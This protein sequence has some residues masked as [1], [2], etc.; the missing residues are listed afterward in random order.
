MDV[1]DLLEQDEVW[2][3]VHGTEHDISDM[4]PRY[5]GNVIRFMERKA[6]ALINGYAWS[7]VKTTSMP[8]ADTHAFDVVTAAFGAELDEMYRDPVAWLRELPLMKALNE[9][10][11]ASE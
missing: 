7:M 9:R 2:V 10:L 4:E 11:A 1:F 8:G 5:V 6:Q 3:D